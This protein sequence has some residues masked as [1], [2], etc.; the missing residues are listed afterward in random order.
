[1]SVR[2]QATGACRERVHGEGASA[3]K[4]LPPRASA[5]RVPQAAARLAVGSVSML[6]GP[7]RTWTALRSSPA[8]V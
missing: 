5:V 2:A 8:I 1:M 7:A 3:A 6:V 4:E